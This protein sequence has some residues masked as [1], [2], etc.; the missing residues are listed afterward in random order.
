MSSR[1]EPKKW[2]YG[3][4]GALLL[5][6]GGVVEYFQGDVTYKRELWLGLGGLLI[7]GVKMLKAKEDSEK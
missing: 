6:A 5:L 7:F 1:P 2:V 4:Y 3:V